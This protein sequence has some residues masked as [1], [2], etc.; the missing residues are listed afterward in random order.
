MLQN[1]RN[2]EVGSLQHHNGTIAVL[3][4]PSRGKLISASED[5][6]IAITR[7]R[8]WTVLS[9]IRAPMPKGANRPSGDTA[10][11]GEAPRGINDFALHPSSKIMISVGRGERCMRLWNLVTGKRAGVLQFEKKMLEAVGEGKHSTGEGRFVRWGTS[12]EEFVVAFERGLA[13]FG[14]DCRVKRVLSLGVRTKVQQV[15]Y[16]EALDSVVAVGTEDGRVCFFDTGEDEV[17]DEEISG[18]LKEKR[19]PRCNIIAQ[20]GG[21]ETGVIGRVK[22][23]TILPLSDEEV[24]E[25]SSKQRLLVTGSSDGTIR[26]WLLDLNDLSSSASQTKGTESSTLAAEKPTT[27]ADHLNTRQIGVLLSKYETGNR[28]TCLKAFI[29]AGGPDDEEDKETAMAVAEEEDNSISEDS[30]SE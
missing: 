16:V 21:K 9:T 22:D 18:E 26:L 28:I 8:D 12:G 25:S 17:E 11:Q 29:M 20:L 2:K 4:F 19:I 1:P 3:S 30:E 10:A 13:V 6:T 23:F 5:N 7:V 27:S 24:A 14:M 15:R